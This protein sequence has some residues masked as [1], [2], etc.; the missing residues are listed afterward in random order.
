[1]WYNNSTSNAVAS[2]AAAVGRA[3]TNPY[4]ETWSHGK[5]EGIAKKKKQQGSRYKEEIPDFSFAEGWEK[6]RKSKKKKPQGSRY[7]SKTYAVLVYEHIYII[8]SY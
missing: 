3:L 4:C 1:M 5:K 7:N 6:R 8:W 2:L